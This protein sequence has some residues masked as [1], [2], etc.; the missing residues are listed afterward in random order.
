MRSEPTNGDALSA[1]LK[2]LPMPN[3]QAA[4]GRVASRIDST[5]SRRNHSYA[6]WKRAVAVPLPAVAAVVLVV[7]SLAV[8]TMSGFLPS[9][10]ASAHV[11]PD[12]ADALDIKVH[13]D[14]SHTADL[15]D[16]LNEQ[17][18]GNVTIQLPDSATFDV[19]GEPVLVRPEELL[20][21]PIDPGEEGSE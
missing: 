12:A 13:V 9:T 1:L 14:A 6:W 15:L 17:D 16:W 5:L 19:L 20:I 4:R 21:E 11:E 7:G 18:V 2:T 8:V 3:V 10:D